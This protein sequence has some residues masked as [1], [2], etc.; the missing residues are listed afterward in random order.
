MASD[1]PG[2]DTPVRLRQMIAHG[3]GQP[4]RTARVRDRRFTFKGLKAGTRYRVV[5]DGWQSTPQ[6]HT[7]NCRPHTTHHADFRII[8]PPQA[9]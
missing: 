8:G 9:G 6:V 7:I 5:A 3:D 1:T 4:S 2:P